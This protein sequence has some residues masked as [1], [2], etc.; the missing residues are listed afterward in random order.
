[1]IR[2]ISSSLLLGESDK[3]Q[4]I[5][6]YEVSKKILLKIRNLIEEEIVRSS[7]KEEQ[8]TMDSNMMIELSNLLGYRRGLREVLKY[9]PEEKS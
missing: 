3:E 4:F 9:L 2:K 8:V 7:L 5:R 6:E 1:M